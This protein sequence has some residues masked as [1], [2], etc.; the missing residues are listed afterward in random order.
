MKYKNSNKH[1]DAIYK[2]SKCYFHLDDNE[3]ADYELNKL[4]NNYPDSEYVKKA[5]LILNN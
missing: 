3:K 2:L 4:V 1:D 5:K